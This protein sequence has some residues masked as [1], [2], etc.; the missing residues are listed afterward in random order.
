MLRRCMTGCEGDA[1][2]TTETYA[3]GRLTLVPGRIAT[4]TL[5]APATRNAMT[6]AMWEALPVIAGRVGGNTDIRVLLV[7]GAG[8]AFSAG[9]DIS[10]FEEVYATAQSA[11]AY[12]ACV[13]AGQAALRAI[14][15]PVIAMIDGPCVGGGCGI[16][17]SCDLRFAAS[18][19]GFAITPARLGIAYSAADTAQLVE[20]VG[21]ARAKDILFSARRLPA[22]EALSIGLIDR[23]CPE[24][25]LL[26]TVTDY[27]D[28]L[29]AL[30]PA[31]MQ[32]TK[33]I[34]NGLT[35]VPGEPSTDWAD[36]DNRFAAL[37]NGPDFA[38]GRAAFA[39][40]R[41]PAF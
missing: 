20:K 30:S 37:F 5:N 22:S 11:Q 36:I 17:L 33:A 23:L 3:D 15:Q 12:N 38:E 18:G 24:D 25:S 34:I 32:V 6:R 27:A 26:S 9:A 14:P 4:L 21:P 8:G 39:A 13:R 31:T 28:S 19:A 2:M 35:C 41:K 10:E 7:T 40:R 16:A 29:A 1:T